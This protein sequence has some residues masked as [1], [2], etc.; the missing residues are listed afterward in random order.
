M[1][2]Y[3]T[4]PELGTEPLKSRTISGE[5]IVAHDVDAL[6][7]T[8]EADIGSSKASLATLVGT[9]STAAVTTVPASAAVVTLAAA[10]ATRFGLIVVNNTTSTSTLCMKF[11][12]AAS[13]SSWSVRIEPGGYWEMPP[14]YYTGIVTGIWSNATGDAH[15]T[16]TG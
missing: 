2:L 6:P 12:S 16:E 9:P 8:V 13:L 5:H 4:D 1:T 7:G 10:K 3:Y 11:G 14:R 15:V